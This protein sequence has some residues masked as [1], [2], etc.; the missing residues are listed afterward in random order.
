MY[1]NIV[2]DVLKEIK[3]AKIL[4]KSGHTV[5]TNKTVANCIMASNNKD[6]YHLK[7]VPYPEGHNLKTVTVIKITED[8]YNSLLHNI[9]DNETFIDC[10]IRSLRQNKIKEMSE[11][12]HK[13]IIGGKRILLSDNKLHHFELSLEDQVNLLE[14]KYLIDHGDTTFIYH[15]TDGLCKEYSLT[16]MKYII[17]ELLKHKQYHIRYFNTLKNH[18]NTLTHINEI[19][20]VYYG[21]TV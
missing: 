17:Q 21:M 18:I 15:E 19:S 11:V 4:K 6:R 12:C 10:G 9:K 14:I 8:E 13:K 20:A 7:G 1:N 3:Y 16:D 5:V 2:I